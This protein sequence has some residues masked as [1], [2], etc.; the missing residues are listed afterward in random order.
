MWLRRQGHFLFVQI[1]DEMQDEQ[2]WMRRRD[3][4]RLGS[5][6]VATAGLMALLPAGAAEAEEEMQNG[7]RSAP[8][9]MVVLHSNQM[10]V[11]LDASDGLPFEYRWR[12]G[13][14][15]LQG[16]DFGRKMRATLCER[17]PWRFFTA[18]LTAESQPT[19]ASGNVSVAAFNFTASDGDRL[20][21]SFQIRYELRD[22]TLLIR[23]E[24]VKESN[25]Y[26]LIDVSMPRLVAVGEQEAGAWLAYGD[27]G[28]SLVMLT[29]ALAGTLPPNSF[30]GRIH[31]SL[32]ITMIGTERLLC[33]QETT[34][35]MDTT[36]VAVTGTKGSRCAAIGSGRV[37]RVNGHDCYNMNLG[38]GAPL[39]C[40]NASTPNLLVEDTPACRLDFLPVAGDARKAWIAA[41]KLVR[42]R[43]PEIPKSFYHDKLIYGI[44]CDEPRFEQPSATFG[45]CRQLI[46]DVNAL[47]D[48]APQIVHLWGWQF[49]GKDT[50][51]PAVNVVD[52]RIGGYD[53]MMALME[54]GR[55]LNATVTLS[56]NYDDAYK[57]SPAWNEAMIARKPDGELWQSRPWTGEVSF[58]Q[59]LAKYMEEGP[60]VERIRY[61]CERYKLPNTTHVDVLSYYAIRNDWD[62]ARPASGIR[63]LRQGRYRVLDEFARHGVDVTSEGLRYPMIGKISCCWYAQTAETC[64]LGGEPI[65]LLPLIYGKSAIWGL[66][67]GT[68][69]D[70]FSLRA[71]HL[72]W[73][74]NLHDILS[75]GIDRQQIT[76][77][78]YLIMVPWLHL[79]GH[80]IE[81]FERDGERAR[82]DLEGNHRIEIDNEAKKYRVMLAGVEAADQDATYC[83]LD[84]DRMCFYSLRA[85]ELSVA[86]P[87]GWNA[88]EAVAVGLSLQKR[89]QV[90]FRVDSGILRITVAERQPVILYRNRALAR[91]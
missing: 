48:G 8:E 15:R 69:G 52:E 41:G 17:G 53:G 57:S 61:T 56:D 11:T 77:H 90:V 13:G 40:G 12:M 60:G 47:T 88:Q 6:S 43:M 16:E 44:R 42:S 21:A 18:D 9:H 86:W 78:Y 64:P 2:Q 84:A 91:L 58:I 87:A 4:L 1:G 24:N 27:S 5:A 59:G 54:Q 66:P 25:G 23:M 33:V 3:F 82:I 55:N 31:G 76:D 83:K 37:H 28:G 85:Q 74:A 62:P 46:A 38:A 73:G 10:E 51:Y 79:A 63:N 67:G 29:D 65:P 89:E 19:Q 36:E 45:Q 7:S 14:A 80:E 68:K 49:K 71:R 34:A 32:P 70:P 30:W 22:A 26:E 72:F 20:C 75:A 35:F 50:G 39:S 81:S